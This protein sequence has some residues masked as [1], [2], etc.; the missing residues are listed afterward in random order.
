[1]A[2]SLQSAPVLLDDGQRVRDLRVPQLVSALTDLGV[3]VP[4]DIFPKAAFWIY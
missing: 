1:M 3:H 4:T 2:H